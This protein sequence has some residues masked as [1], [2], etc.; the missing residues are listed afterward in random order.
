MGVTRTEM[1]IREECRAWFRHNNQWQ[2]VSIT[3]V[4]QERGRIM[5]RVLVGGKEL[6]VPNSALRFSERKPR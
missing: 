4:I 1:P 6:V 3:A 5:N 2:R